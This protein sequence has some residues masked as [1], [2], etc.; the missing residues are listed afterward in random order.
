MFHLAEAWHTRR[1]EIEE[2]PAP[3]EIG[4]YAIAMDEKFA[5]AFANAGG[6]QIQANL[7]GEMTPTN[8][9]MWTPLGVVRFAREGWDSRLGPSDGADLESSGVTFAPEFRENGKWLRMADLPKRYE[10][11]WS[12]KFVHPLLVRCAVD[13]RPKSGETGPSFRNE[14]VI[15]PDGIFSTLTRTSR[16]EIPWGVTWPILENDGTA[17]ERT[18]GER[19]RSVGYPGAADRQNYIAVDAAEMA[20]EALLRSSYGDLR[21]I[22]V[23]ASG[24]WQRTFIYPQGAGDPSASAVRDSLVV[25]RDGWRSVLGTVGETTYVGRTAA[26]GFAKEIDLNRDGRPDVRFS[27][28]CGFLIQLDSGKPVA[29]E[30]DQDVEVRINGKSV[31][32]VRHQPRRL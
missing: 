18:S 11:V 31:K 26:G 7:R 13:Y 9:N 23:P 17:L 12:V 4:G 24:S 27:K 32:L 29:I 1:H 6:M 5:S 8:G 21:P 14:F 30:A 19:L 22:R 2:Q 10:G 15:T 16:E 28:P 3:S 25:T 20:E